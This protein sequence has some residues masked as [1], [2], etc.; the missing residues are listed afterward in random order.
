M[1]KINVNIPNIKKNFYKLKKNTK[2]LVEEG[3]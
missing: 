2:N 1:Y 3:P